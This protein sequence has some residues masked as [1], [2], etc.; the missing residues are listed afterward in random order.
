MYYIYLL[1]EPES[2]I[3]KYIGYSKNPKERY[4]N[5]LCVGKEKSLKNSWIKSL[6]SKNL[7]PHLSIIDSCEDFDCINNLEIQW[8]K[9]FKE[10]GFI[11]K[12]GTLGGGGKRENSVKKETRELISKVLTEKYK[13]ESHKLKGRKWSEERKLQKSNATK[14]KKNKNF[15]FEGRKQSN[16]KKVIAFK[17][18]IIYKEYECLYDASKDLNINAGAI[19]NVCNNKCKTAKGFSFKFKID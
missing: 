11:L 18:G 13:K 6:K 5:H 4:S 2:L 3:P 14:G 7:K 10:Q 17:E 1:S 16:R 12:N 8:I 9:Y 19:S 15:T